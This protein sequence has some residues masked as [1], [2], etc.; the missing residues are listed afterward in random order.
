MEVSEGTDVTVIYESN[1]A[2]VGSL[3]V[4]GFSA[5]SEVSEVSE[6]SEVSAVSE[7]SEASKVSEFRGLRGFRGVLRYGAVK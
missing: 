7:V 6:A 1:I 3:E 2:C 5:V 4:F